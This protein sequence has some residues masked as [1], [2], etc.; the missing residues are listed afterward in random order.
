MK[1]V[2]NKLFRGN[3]FC[4]E[5]EDLTTNNLIDLS[6]KQI[7]VVYGPNGAGKTSFTKVLSQEQ[8]AKYLIEIDGRKYSEKDSKIVHII[9]DQNGRNIIKGETDE[10][11]IGINIKREHELRKQLDEGFVD[12]FENLLVNELKNRFG[13]STKDSTLIFLISNTFL[14]SYISQIANN[15][16]KGRSINRDEFLREIERIPTPSKLSYEI[17]LFSFFIND[18]KSKDSIIGY[19]DSLD[20]EKIEKKPIAQQ[21]E[22]T[23]DAISILE[24]Y[25]YRNDCVVCDSSIERIKLLE[26]KRKQNE[27]ANSS[28]DPA[29]KEVIAKIIDKVTANDPFEFKIKL[30]FALRTGEK[31]VLQKLKV[32]IDYYKSVF[33]SVLTSTII[34]LVKGSNLKDINDEYNKILQE[35]PKLEDEDILYIKSFLSE[36]FDRKIDLIRSTDK[37][38][39]LVLGEDEFLGKNRNELGLSNGEQNFLS[40]SFEL[41]KAK[42]VSHKI[43]L[44]DDPISSFDSIYKNKIA[45]AI[46]K[47]LVNKKTIV[48]T[49][50]T[51]L[52]KL[53][54]HQ[55]RNCFVLYY[56]NNTHGEENGFVYIRPTEIKLLLYTYE[57]LSLLRDG[58]KDEIVDEEAFLVSIIPFMRGYSKLI[59][60][61]DLKNKLTKLMH[62]YE[63]ECQNLTEIYDE[64]FGTGIITH[65]HTLSVNEIMSIDLSKPNILKNDNYPLL[66]KTL[67]HT[68]SYL[69]LRLHVE[70]KLVEKFCIN[71]QKNEMLTEII[72]EAFKG[73]NVSDIENRVFFLSRK[74]L[75]NEF[76]HFETD[77]NIFQPAIDINNQTLQREKNDILGRLNDL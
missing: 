36:C 8:H 72:Q 77:L 21:I 29:T 10:F 64:L 2:V 34:D 22:E 32:M 67:S 44:L 63:S 57:F 49:H 55:H 13:I 14:R 50:N 47:F 43:I 62:G 11:L 52:I 27:T 30:T 45:Y 24:K 54:E 7:A 69:Y 51:D 5:Y 1:I 38:L 66:N 28:L 37:T 20:L 39:K 4:E 71:T 68:L 70:K 53:L 56:M 25:D 58:I 3:I 75:L 23:K 12:L 6:R 19:F 33:D 26:K 42:K 73:S 16:Q 40:L 65:D 18:L 15:K 76:N 61:D 60:R 9:E 17:E 31:D 41:L 59:N 48:L 46:I 35:K 74:T